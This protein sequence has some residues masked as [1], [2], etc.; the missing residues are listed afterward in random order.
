M[1]RIPLRPSLRLAPDQRYFGA[2]SPPHAVACRDHTLQS[3]PLV[4]S[5]TIG[6]EKERKHKSK[7]KLKKKKRKKFMVYNWPRREHIA[8]FQMVHGKQEPV[9]F[10]N[11]SLMLLSDESAIISLFAHLASSILQG[12]RSRRSK[13]TTKK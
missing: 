9:T 12:R 6:K 1:C 11:N 8:C 13:K 5:D 10:A 3:R 7:W 4:M 2:A